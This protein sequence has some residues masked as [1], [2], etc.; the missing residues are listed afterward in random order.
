MEAIV[1]IILQ[2]FFE[3]RAVFQ[4]WRIF[5]HMT[6]L[7]QSGSSDNIWWMT[8]VADKRVTA[9]KIDVTY[10][11]VSWRPTKSDNTNRYHGRVV[12]IFHWLIKAWRKEKPL[13]HICM[14]SSSI[15]LE[16]HKLNGKLPPPPS[17]IPFTR[18]TL[19]NNWK[20][21]TV[22]SVLFRLT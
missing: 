1:F 4:N 22:K 11:A 10:L 20:L 19:T 7:D 6:R 21:I 14:L 18:I 15:K 2:I 12:A 8:K 9:A 17:P 16:H 5:S 13:I 3:T